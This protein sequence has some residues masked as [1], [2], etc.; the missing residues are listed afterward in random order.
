M[1]ASSS[2]SPIPK[3]KKEK[4]E[5]TTESIDIVDIITKDNE[6]Q[7][8]DP[9]FQRF[10]YITFENHD[11][12]LGFMFLFDRLCALAISDKNMPYN[13]GYISDSVAN[14]LI[15]NI[16][17]NQKIV[18]ED[19]KEFKSQHLDS[20]S[21]F[22][23]LRW[24]SSDFDLK[25]LNIEQ[26][27][28]TNLSLLIYKQKRW[29]LHFDQVVPKIEFDSFPKEIFYK[30]SHYLIQCIN[31]LLI[32]RKLNMYFINDRYL[33]EVIFA[34]VKI[35]LFYND[36][37]KF[38]KTDLY[39]ENVFK[40]KSFEEEFIG[41]NVW[42]RQAWTIYISVLYT[43]NKKF[44]YLLKDKK[45][46]SHLMLK[47]L[48]QSIDFLKS[49][50][51]EFRM[52]LSDTSQKK[53]KRTLK[54][55]DEYLNALGAMNMAYYSIQ[56][57]YLYKKFDPFLKKFQEDNGFVFDH[58]ILINNAWFFP[59]F[60]SD[61]EQKEINK[62]VEEN[63]DIFSS[64]I[65]YEDSKHFHSF[66]ATRT[67]GTSLP[68]RYWRAYDFQDSAAVLFNNSNLEILCIDTSNYFGMFKSYEA[69]LNQ[70][71]E[72]I[73][74]IKSILKTKVSNLHQ[75]LM[76]EIKNYNQYVINDDIPLYNARKLISSLD[77]LNNEQKK[78][79]KWIKFNMNNSK[80]VFVKISKEDEGLNE[81][82]SETNILIDGNIIEDAKASSSSY[83]TEIIPRE[84]YIRYD[85]SNIIQ[86]KKM[87][88]LDKMKND[89]QLA[90]SI[91]RNF[92]VLFDMYF[93]ECRYEI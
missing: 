81:T 29:F 22:N 40:P 39:H 28:S 18:M 62:D 54:F 89:I 32:N 44:I 61:L 85:N 1:Q 60:R 38:A 47:D 90:Q 8:L 53:S 48:K 17:N 14:K 55:S 49:K 25:E 37:S 34:V 75:M 15:K 13:N 42:L 5:D 83:V 92:E 11:E 4:N 30:F 6:N 80:S 93:P 86:I 52:Q 66:R 74:V 24:I 78:D 50:I 26:L 87:I 58:N 21:I 57:Y 41:R 12:N 63:I 46:K 27:F 72:K 59:K 69:D 19:H 31:H 82:T 76:F 2:S 3:I 51:D 84:K 20:N 70:S 16:H 77:E 91:L 65:L 79:I 10:F 88:A 43:E 67:A 7:I 35:L 9:I 64:K 73:A 45:V 56:I 23:Y 36:G 68:L 71:N 33:I